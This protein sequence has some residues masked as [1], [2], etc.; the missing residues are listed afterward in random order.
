MHLISPGNIKQVR[1]NIKR[2]QLEFASLLGVTNV[3]VSRWENPDHTAAPRS[4]AHIRALQKLME[5]YL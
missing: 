2:S 5:K 4:L 3:T 1:M